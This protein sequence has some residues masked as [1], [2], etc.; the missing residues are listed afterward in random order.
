MQEVR[1]PFAGKVCEDG[2]GHLCVL[3][4]E[5]EERSYTIPSSRK[6]VV[7][8]GQHITAGTPLTAGALDPQEILRTVGKEA[9]QQ[10]LVNEVRGVYRVAGVYIHDKHFEVIVREML[11]HVIVDD[12]GDTHLLP[13]SIVDRFDYAD[14]S[15]RILAQGGMP[16]QARIVLLGLTRTALASPSWLAAAAFQEATRVLADAVLEGRTDHIEALKENVMLGRLIPAGTGF[17]SLQ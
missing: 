13:G 5:R 7:S 12:V 16:P 3:A 17:R 4:I 6:L 9:V 8:Q 14:L 1:A 15:A 2:S 10:Y 11:R